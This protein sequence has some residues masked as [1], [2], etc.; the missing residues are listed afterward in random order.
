[1]DNSNQYIGINSEKYQYLNPK[2]ISKVILNDGTTYYLNEN[3]NPMNQMGNCQ[4]SHM[5]NYNTSVNQINK[6]EMAKIKKFNSFKTYKNNINK[7]FT[8]FYVTPINNIPKR[9]LKIKIPQKDL[10]N[11]EDKTEYHVQNFTFKASPKKYSYKPYKPP[12]RKNN[13][14]TKNNQTDI[15]I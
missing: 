10:N 1:M 7:D 8:T 14:F 13:I 2:T 6:N 5:Y 9:L 12:K 3:T 15:K 11:Q 4:N